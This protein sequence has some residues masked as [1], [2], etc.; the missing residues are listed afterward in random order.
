MGNQSTI[1]FI[2][3]QSTFAGKVRGLGGVL[4]D[5][6]SSALICSGENTYS[7]RLCP[8]KVIYTSGNST[9]PVFAALPDTWYGGQFASQS[10]VVHTCLMQKRC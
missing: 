8:Q 10:P 2:N 7:D 6:P 9:L 5:M 1:K 4:E 3:A